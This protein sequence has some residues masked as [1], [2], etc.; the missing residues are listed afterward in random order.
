MP[1]YNVVVHVVGDKLVTIDAP[2]K[3]A[4]EQ[5]FEGCDPLTSI[6]EYTEGFDS[7]DALMIDAR[8][9]LCEVEDPANCIPDFY[10]DVDGEASADPPEE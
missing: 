10:V 4:V 7:N 2:S 3:E 9:Q 8:G 1:R 5:F 6:I